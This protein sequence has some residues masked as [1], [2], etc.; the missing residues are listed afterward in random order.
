MHTSPDPETLPCL[1]DRFTPGSRPLYGQTL[2][3][4]KASVRRDLED[5][6]NTRQRVVSPPPGLDRL[7]MSVVNY[8]VPDP[9]GFDLSSK[10]RIERFRDGIETA[11]KCFEKRFRRVNVTLAS[12][13]E[14]SDR[15]L[16][17]WIEAFVHVEHVPERLLFA[18]DVEPMTR[19]MRVK[20]R[21][22][23]E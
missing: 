16:R 12:G 19:E 8:G 17:F 20:G 13:G 11:I 6:L 18:L 22:L 1:L 9:L 14:T 21:R 4:V 23:Q 15:I 5:L 3:Q 2:E 7:A 10:A